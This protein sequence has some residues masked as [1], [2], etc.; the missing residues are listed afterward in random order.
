[1]KPVTKTVV[2][3]VIVLLTDGIIVKLND[4][5]VWPISSSVFGS[6]VGSGS[7]SPHSASQLLSTVTKQTL[8]VVAGSVGLAQSVP[9]QTHH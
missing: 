9:E 2:H 5:P 1:M 7:Y 3:S 8:P 6:Q 4:S